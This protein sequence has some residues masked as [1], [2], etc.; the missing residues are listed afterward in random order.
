M[1]TRAEQVADGRLSM[2]F[3]TN[4]YIGTPQMPNWLSILRLGQNPARVVPDRSS[5]LWPQSAM[6]DLGATGLRT[7]KGKRRSVQINGGSSQQEEL[8]ARSS[9]QYAM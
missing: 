3:V 7:G 9:G 4:Y 6:P 2:A 1:C 8:Y 5:F